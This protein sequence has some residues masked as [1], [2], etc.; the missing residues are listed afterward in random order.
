MLLH[1]SVN[2]P[3]HSILMSNVGDTELIKTTSAHLF[4]F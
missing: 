4:N 2:P 3:P 1:G